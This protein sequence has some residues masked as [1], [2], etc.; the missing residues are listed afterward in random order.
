[1]IPFLNNVG[2]KSYFSLS[3]HVVT[4]EKIYRIILPAGGIKNV[5]KLGRERTTRFRNGIANTPEI[6]I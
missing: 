3:V 2:L 1:L 4:Q 5:A 6:E